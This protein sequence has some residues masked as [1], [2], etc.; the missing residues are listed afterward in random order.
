MAAQAATSVPRQRSR[1]PRVHPPVRLW[2]LLPSA[3]RRFGRGGTKYKPRPVVNGLCGK[4]SPRRA[5]TSFPP[6]EG[7][8]ACVVC[9][10]RTRAHRERVLDRQRRYATALPAANCT[11]L[12]ACDSA[13]SRTA[14]CQDVLRLVK[15]EQQERA[16]MLARYHND[17][18]ACQIKRMG[19]GGGDVAGEAERLASVPAAGPQRPPSPTSFVTEFERVAS[20]GSQQE[21]AVGMDPAH[22][23]RTVGVRTE[24][25]LCPPH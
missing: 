10:H 20:G 21:A 4:S 8:K 25:R 17:P 5:G 16:E 7:G 15:Q 24:R 6:G 9:L 18:R 14:R 3:A 19:P 22:Q 1:T 13:D 11:E 23:V 2:L 12:S